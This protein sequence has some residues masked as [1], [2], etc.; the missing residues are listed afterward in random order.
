MSDSL[1]WYVRIL[2]EFPGML[3]IY[4]CISDCCIGPGETYFLFLIPDHLYVKTT[5]F[6]HF[7]CTLVQ[8]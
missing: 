2:S 7:S 8:A 5:N 3:L 4:K 6:K 1:G